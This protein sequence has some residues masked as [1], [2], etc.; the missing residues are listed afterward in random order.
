MS[1]TS[2]VTESMLSYLGDPNQAGWPCSRRPGNPTDRHALDVGER[3]HRRLRHAGTT[4]Q[5]CLSTVRQAHRNHS[6]ATSKMLKRSASIDRS[7]VST[8]STAMYSDEDHIILKTVKMYCRSLIFNNRS[9]KK[10]K[11]FPP[12]VGGGYFFFCSSYQILLHFALK[13]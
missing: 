5:K 3:Y 10:P 8:G 6:V 13:N 12:G 9:E 7:Q 2:I 11:L 4:S 1:S